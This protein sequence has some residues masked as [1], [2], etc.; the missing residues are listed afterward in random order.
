[1]RIFRTFNVEASVNSMSV[2]DDFTHLI[3]HSMACTL[4]DG[5]GCAM[6]HE[7]LS[8][9]SLHEEIKN[10]F[11]ECIGQGKNK[12]FEQGK[13]KLHNARILC[14]ALNEAWH[15]EGCLKRGKS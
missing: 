3:V 15:K 2:G 8:F 13:K 6:G 10:E 11:L 7:E 5:V 14:H 4:E 12:G 9:R 1:M